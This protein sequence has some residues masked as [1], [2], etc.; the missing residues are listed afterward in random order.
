MRIK[1][2]SLVLFFFFTSA[3]IYPQSDFNEWI[4]KEN[5]KFN[6]FI[7]E[8]DKKFI[9]FLENEWKKFKLFEG[10][11]KDDVPKPLKLPV[12]ESTNL[13][14]E[15]N[16]LDNSNREKNNSELFLE[17]DSEINPEDKMP[18]KVK[19]EMPEIDVNNSVNISA[20]P[21]K[22]DVNFYGNQTMFKFPSKMEYDLDNKISDKVFSEYWKFLSTKN[23][24]GILEQSLYYKTSKELNDWGYIQF[25]KTIAESIY[26]NQ[27]NQKHLFV[28]FMLIKSGYKVK[29]GIIDNNAFIFFP[30][31]HNIYEIP[32]FQIKKNSDRLYILDLDNNYQNVDGYLH[33]YEND[34]PNT[35]KLMDMRISKFPR[36]NENYATKK[37][38]WGKEDDRKEI[39]VS[40]NEGFIKFLEDY[41]YSDLSIYFNSIVSPEFK[42]TILSQLGRLAKNKSKKEVVDLLLEFVQGS[43]EYKTDQP[44]FGREKPL[45]PEETVYYPF[46][47]C[48]DRAAIF[49]YLVRNLTNLKVIGIDYPGHVATA[50]KFK[51]KISGSKI[52]HDNEEYIICDPTFL[53]ATVGQEM[54]EYYHEQYKAVIKIE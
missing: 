26:P 15:E 38:K 21:V 20:L 37:L 10:I 32:F 11:K 33:T 19:L 45:F 23:Y 9:L 27:R 39:E 54:P 30:A 5:E 17:L 3:C 47:D 34:Y 8:D 28:W 52:I 24:Y 31:T 4:K 51:N 36:I 16:N 29:A 13:K 48:E 6:K 7:T 53:G 25:L 12:I 42:K 49:A 43:F 44:Q 41:P 35:E 46:S 18:G 22:R 50:V 40:Y 2:N 1:Y 14:S